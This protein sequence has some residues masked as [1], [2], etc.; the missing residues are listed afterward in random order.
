MAHMT[1]AFVLALMTA[2]HQQAPRTGDA[3]AIA[4]AIAWV[5]SHEKAPAL[6]TR[7]F[8]AAVLVVTGW[9]ESRYRMSAVGDG[10]LSRCAFQV[11]GG[12]LHDPVGCVARALHF[13]RLGARMCPDAPL[14]P[15]CG[16]CRGEMPRR[17]SA[18]RMAEARR[19]LER[20]RS[21]KP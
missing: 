12:P 7:E 6:E 9:H 19:I 18:F 21:G 11:R 10:G 16:S 20:A 8:D 2:L 4:S 1:L 17:I 14:A 15:Y 5:V 13:I 3:Y